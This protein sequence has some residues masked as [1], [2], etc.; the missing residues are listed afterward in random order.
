MENWSDLL[1]AVRAGAKAVPAVRYALGV[2]GLFAAAAIGKSLFD[3]SVLL[4]AGAASVMLF[5]MVLLVVFARSAGQGSHANRAPQLVLIWFVIGF[6]IVTAITLFSCVFFGRPLDLSRIVGAAPVTVAAESCLG[7]DFVTTPRGKLT[8]VGRLS[9]PDYDA[10]EFISDHRSLNVK[11]WK[12]VPDHLRSV[13]VSPATLTRTVSVRKL[14]DAEQIEFPASTTGPELGF[15]LEGPRNYHVESLDVELTG[16][17]SKVQRN[18]QIVVDVRDVPVG[19]VFNLTYCCT[20]WNS[21]E[22]DDNS[23]LAL[24][25]RARTEQA[26]LSVSFPPNRPV[27]GVQ[28]WVQRY[29]SP[30]REPVTDDRAA[31][32]DV[33]AG[34]GVAFAID[35]PSI[36]DAYVIDWDW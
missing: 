14:H 27:R 24:R 16:S 18:Y 15:C 3:G 36:G 19:G 26:S 35:R 12:P 5:L 9:D 32:F 23:F 10:F 33:L 1:S 2:V 13:P 21:F 8:S 30:A 17:K 34:L 28:T 7:A 20:Y 29:G 25:T 22:F 4:A 11:T 6:S 31:R